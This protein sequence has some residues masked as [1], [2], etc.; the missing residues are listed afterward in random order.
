MVRPVGRR[1]GRPDATQHDPSRV[2][3]PAGPADD[4][5]TDEGPADEGPAD[6]RPPLRRAPMR[7]RASSA[8]P[9]DA[10]DGSDVAHTAAE[11][12]RHASHELFRRLQ[13]CVPGSPEWR[14]H[15][16][17][18]VR[19]HLPLA[20][21]LV[22]RFAGRGEPMDDLIQVATIG[23]IK[24]VDR[25]D[26]ERGVEFSTYATPTVVGE[27]KRHFRDRGWAIRVPR[28]MQEHTL[29]VSRATGDLFGRLSRSPTIAELA[30]YTHLTEEEVLEA[31]G[32]AHAYTT[33]SLDVE[34]ADDSPGG[35]AHPAAGDAQVALENVEHRASLRPL[36]NRLN[37]RERQILALRFFANMTQSEIAAEI[38][39]SQMHVS[40]LLSRTLAHLREGLGHPE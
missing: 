23:L 30:G 4:R 3:V 20:H 25:F 1:T 21:Y 2:P 17:E 40:R 31:I 39:V 38:G 18:L 35:A 15:R 12:D 10:A 16:D 33:V 5:T 11:R 28:R 19:R 27:V 14:V 13:A 6:E 32:S 7:R 24:A 34:L 37:P 8:D 9:A 29:A 22:R 26:L 36:L